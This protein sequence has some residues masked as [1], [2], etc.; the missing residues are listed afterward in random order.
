MFPI[1]Y[2][3][4]SVKILILK[5]LE[6][7]SKFRTPLF[8][9]KTNKKLSNLQQLCP[10]LSSWSRWHICRRDRSVMGCR[11]LC[12]RGSGCRLAV[13]ADDCLCVRAIRKRQVGQQALED[14]I[15]VG[16]IL[17]IRQ[18]HHVFIQFIKFSQKQKVN[19]NENLD[20]L[21]NTHL[22]FVLKITTW[23]QT[24]RLW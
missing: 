12:C 15:E 7:E 10:L 20:E 9:K 16:H 2:C 14:A 19:F 4:A 22:K 1:S 18:L 5:R 8:I 23:L 24:P 17:K 21:K 3:H 13:L 6:S 11:K